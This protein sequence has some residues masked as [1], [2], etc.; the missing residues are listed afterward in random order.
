MSRLFSLT[1]LIFSLTLQAC[2]G[3]HFRSA[4]QSNLKAIGVEKIFIRGIK[5]ESFKP[6]V[7]H[8]IMQALTRGLLT[9]GSVKLV[10]DEKEAD[11][12]LEGRILIAQYRAIVRTTSGAIYPSSVSVGRAQIATEYEAS[13]ECEF[14]LKRGGGVVDVE[15]LFNQTFS[16]QR[17]FA[18][19]NQ[20]ASY[21]TTSPL[22]NESEF[23]R[24]LGELSTSMM[25]DVQESLLSRF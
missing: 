2:G 3:Y 12:V 15:P 9:S 8:L 19:S 1:L 22:V 7:E 21:G 18:G 14:V 11:A 13:L 4:S 6:G 24:A 17:R 25:R 5:N 10:Q 16:N 23:G 20:K